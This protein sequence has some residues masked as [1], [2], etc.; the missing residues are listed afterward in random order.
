MKEYLYKKLIATRLEVSQGHQ[1]RVH[2]DLLHP[3]TAHLHSICYV[4]LPI[5]ML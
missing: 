4:R 2:H 3:S 1:T 5:S